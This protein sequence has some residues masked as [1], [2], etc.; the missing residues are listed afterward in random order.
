MTAGTDI[1][2]HKRELHFYYLIACGPLFIRNRCDKQ[3][4][5]AAESRADTTYNT[6]DSDSRGGGCFSR[7]RRVFPAFWLN[8]PR[9]V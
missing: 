1:S 3:L 7:E 6:S 2:S 5:S 8:Q 9:N 4:A